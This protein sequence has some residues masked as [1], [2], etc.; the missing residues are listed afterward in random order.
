MKRYIFYFQLLFLI[1]FACGGSSG[2]NHFVLVQQGRFYSTI[3]E[4]GELRAVNSKS[5]SAPMI[6]GFFEQPKVVELAAEGTY[7]KKG[8]VIGELDNSKV[9]QRLEGKK[10]E[11]AIAE[12][13]FNKLKTSQ[14][15]ELK[16]LNAS[17]KSS[18]ADLRSVK[19]RAEKDKFES[20]TKRE[21]SKVSLQIAEI[22]YNRTIK[23]I[24]KTKIMHNEDRLIN[25]LKLSQIKSDIEQ[26]KKAIDAYTLRAPANGMIEYGQIWSGSGRRKV[27]VGDQV[28]WG[29]GII[30]LPDMSQ[31]KVIATVS[32]MDIGKVHVGQKAYVRLDAF[33][34]KAFTG[35]IISVSNISRKKDRQ[36][37]IKVF[38]LV[39]LLDDVD[40]ILKPGMTV[41]CEFVIAEFKDTLFVNSNCIRQEGGEYFVYVENGNGPKKTKVTVGPKNSKEAMVKGNLNPGDKILLKNGLGEI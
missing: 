21:I 29:D 6:R 32:E 26:A 2:N 1:C 31:M 28:W 5:V 37:K 14:Q 22:N 7:V 33:P 36:S 34:K 4:T 23:K 12:S 11:L 20:P 18:E 35:S 16:E 9:M 13:E 40:K 19:L 24:E 8:D 39:V 15:N 38:D 3:T 17:L 30:L 41:S 27:A 25:E 10:R